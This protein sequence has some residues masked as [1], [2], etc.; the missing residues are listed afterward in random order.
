MKPYTDEVIEAIRNN[1][2]HHENEWELLGFVDRRNKIYTFGHDSKII[3]RLFEVIA[4]QTLQEAADELNYELQESLKQTVYPDFFMIKPNGRKIAIDVK[5]TYKKYTTKGNLKRFAFTLGS[6]T[7]YLRN[8]EKNIVG[9]YDEYDGHYVLAFTYNRNP[10]ASDG[11][12]NVKD[13]KQLNAAYTNPD[14]I[15]MEKH[16][17]GG[18][19][20][21]SGNTDNISTFS[22]NNLDSFNHGYGPFSFLGEE[23][24]EHYWRNYP[25]NKDTASEKA[26]LYTNLPSYFDWLER[27]GHT[28]ISNDLREKYNRFREF[29][30]VNNYDIHIR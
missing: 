28:A 16:R 10:D 19:T 7:S 25:R 13:L 9:K 12:Y 23:T 4:K 17:L 8:N 1:L 3:G 29:T 24:F 27:N 11:I 26:E 18:D 22:S 21:G 15:V 6:F 2:P 5:T 14:V 30:E 20:K